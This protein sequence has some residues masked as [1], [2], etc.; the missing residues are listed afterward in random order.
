MSAL[1]WPHWT[2]LGLLVFFAGAV[3][4]LAGGGGLITLP[5]YM[6]FGLEPALLL[7]TNKL[8]ATIGAAGSAYRYWDKLRI[9]LKPFLPVIFAA[10]LGSM[11]GARLTLLL[12]P[13]WLRPMLLAALPLVAVAVYGGK[14]LG[15]EGGAEGAA[16][17]AIDRR[18]SALAG[19]IGAYQGF[20]GPGAGTFFALAL[21]R[22]CGFGL[23]GATARAKVLDL[24]S[25]VA[26]VAA[27]LLQGRLDWRVGLSM[28][29]VSVAGHAVGSHVGLERGATA[30]RP[31][32]L[33]VL[34]GLFA[35]LAHDLWRLQG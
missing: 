21:A 32:I 11:A 28:G 3:D 29:L 6:A 7:G 20:F 13:A 19:V 26:A 2:L 34:A 17:P 24:V 31:A 18:L 15:A 9:P 1:D 14:R 27:F 16:P 5:A 35:K 8:S 33:L 23:L 12:D 4:S 22:L 30:I 25:N 10:W